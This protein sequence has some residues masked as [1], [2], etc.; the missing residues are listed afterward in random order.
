[1]TNLG[2]LV[3]FGLVAYNRYAKRWASK[4]GRYSVPGKIT[5][6]ERIALSKGSKM[7]VSYSYNVAG[8]L[9]VGEVPQ[10][11]WDM[12]KFIA[13]HPKGKE[14]TVYFAPKDPNFSRIEQPPSH[15]DIIGSTLLYWLLLPLLGINL[16]SAYLH[17]LVKIA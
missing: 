12:D 17:W 6:S 8:N 15:F 2:I 1:M 16:V 4:T 13:D 7:L 3:L 5:W 10:K 9:Y 14:V 11:Y